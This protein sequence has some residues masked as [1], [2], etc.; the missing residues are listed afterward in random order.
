MGIETVVTGIWLVVVSWV[1]TS[2]YVARLAALGQYTRRA[3]YV[4]LAI[5]ASFLFLASL[6]LS[7]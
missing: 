7:F 5:A 6:V 3:Y 4:F 2:L 1:A